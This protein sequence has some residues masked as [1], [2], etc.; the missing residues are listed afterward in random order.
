MAKEFVHSTAIILT[1]VFLMILVMAIC[2]FL[3]AKK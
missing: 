1:I 3:K 2:Q